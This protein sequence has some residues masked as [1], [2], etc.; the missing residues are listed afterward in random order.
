MYNNSTGTLN[1]PITGGNYVS[2]YYQTNYTN[3]SNSLASGLA[4][5]VAAYFY[6]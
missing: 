1:I 2:F 5:N 3:T 4:V 6:V